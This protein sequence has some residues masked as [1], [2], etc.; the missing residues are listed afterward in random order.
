MAGHT[1]IAE[2]HDLA[3]EMLLEYRTELEHRW[4]AG[5]K[6][7]NLKKV[8]EQLNNLDLDPWSYAD[9]LDNA[10]SKGADAEKVMKE[11]RNHQ[12]RTMK[13]WQVLSDD[14]IH[15]I[16]GKRTGGNSLAHVSGNVIREAVSRLV[17][18]YGHRFANHH[19]NFKNYSEGEHKGQPPKKGGL[20]EASGVR[21]TDFRHLMAHPDGSTSKHARN[22]TPQEMQDV[23]SVVEAL[24]EII[25]PQKQA[26]ANADLLAKPRKD[27]ANEIFGR[28]IY[29]ART[30]FDQEQLKKELK[31]KTP[32]VEEELIDSYK[33]LGSNITG[34]QALNISRGATHSSNDLLKVLQTNLQQARAKYQIDEI[35]KAADNP[36]A[37]RMSGL[38]PVA[39]TALG[40]TF[41]DKVAEDRDKEIKA[42]PNDASLKVNKRLDQIS[43]WGDRT[44]LAGMGVLAGGDAA[45]LLGIPMMAAGEATSLTAGLG[46]LAIDAA[47]QVPKSLTSLQDK[48]IQMKKSVAHK[49][50]PNDYGITEALRINGPNQLKVFADLQGALRLGT[51]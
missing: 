12:S 29:G 10:M 25:T 47:R 38:L 4:K 14:T 31:L 51:R 18:E 19:S 33:L 3:R 22:L 28:D 1:D 2:L 21:N 41:M 23:D 40:A 26:A 37:R 42:N 36:L 20:E 16:V 46:S 50:N 35:A 6:S 44:S 45:S 8:R 5:D 27:R 17:D 43:G 48:A 49:N 15:H 30:E 34:N 13:L 11:L 9:I 24:R 32:D 39:G 7:S